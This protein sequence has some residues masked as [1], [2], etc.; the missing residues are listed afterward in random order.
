MRR[1]E[2]GLAQAPFCCS[3]PSIPKGTIAGDLRT[4][5]HEEKMYKQARKKKTKAIKK[6][7]RR[8]LK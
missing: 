1:R 7:R 5:T 4:I 2:H 6:A 8:N 3:T